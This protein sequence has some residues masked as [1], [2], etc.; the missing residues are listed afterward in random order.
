MVWCLHFQNG[1]SN[2]KVTCIT[3]KPIVTLH[4]CLGHRCETQVTVKNVPKDE[5]ENMVHATNRKIHDFK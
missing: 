4:R 3:T 2:G 5:K 1:F